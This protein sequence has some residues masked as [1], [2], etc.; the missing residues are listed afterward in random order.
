M[1]DSYSPVRGQAYAPGT[2]RLI[3]AEL[4]RSGLELRLCDAAGEVLARGTP[5]D[6]EV[7]PAGRDILSFDEGMRFETTDREGLRALGVVTTGGWLARLEG[8]HPRLALL[9]VVCILGAIAIWRWGLDLLVSLA[10][11]ATPAP[12]VTSMDRGNMLMIDRTFAEESDLSDARQAEIRDIFDALR[13]VAPEAPY[14]A[15]TLE[16][17][18]I[19]EMGPNA[20]ALPGGTI[21]VTDALIEQFGDADVIA[22]VLGHE[23]AHIS[24]RHSLRQLYRS[25]SVYVLIGMMA[26]D[27]GPVLED[28]ILD[29]GVV[30][31]LAY[32]RTHE[33]AADDVGV[34]TAEA[35]GYDG[36]ALAGFFEELDRR[37]G[38]L[39]PEWMSTHPDSA[40]RAARIR[41][42]Q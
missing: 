13:S 21:V 9:A 4:Q 24:E 7:G 12:V 16:F 41:E 38:G 27:V 26:G 15:Y 33:R 31:S 18:D 30:L 23:M 35:A 39:A 28:L 29:G 34:R 36:A 1:A 5:I 3:A 37:Y 19:D 42:M 22:G 32:S 14:G 25:L 20:F 40:D 17:R 10:I 8:W 6:H 2:S 11:L